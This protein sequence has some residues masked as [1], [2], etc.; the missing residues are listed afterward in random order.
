MNAEP[1]LEEINQI[2]KNAGVSKT[3]YSLVM[4]ETEATFAR[5]ADEDREGYF[6][7]FREAWT[8]KQDLLHESFF[9]QWKCWVAT[10]VKADWNSFPLFYPTG[11]ASEALRELISSYGNRARAE[12]FVPRIHL[13][14]G[15]YEGFSAYAQASHIETL[16]HPRSQ[17]TRAI[18]AMRETDQVYLSDPSAIDG[19]L[20]KDYPEFMREM[21]LRMPR[22]EVTVDLT[23]VGCVAREFSVDVAFPN[24]SAVVFSLSKPMGVYYHRVGGCLSR[25]PLPGLFGNKWFKNITS[26]RLGEEMMRQYSVRE[27]P[28]KYTALQ[29]EALKRASDVVGMCLQ[30][31]DVFLLGS[32]PMPTEPTPL[33]KY[34]RRDDGTDGI[35]RACLTPTIAG[36]I[37]PRLNTEVRARNHEG[38]R[39]L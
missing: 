2:L 28:A 17:W 30:A 29:I 38:H 14:S 33:Q 19:N 39:R 32:C 23:Y 10:A 16:F 35:I 11:G 21:S 5:I 24:I 37:D 3:I 27:L 12:G 18:E 13:F 36:L 22:V 25:A 6:S 31:S 15:E 1:S 7:L 9:E 8:Q 20:W 26:L 34:L 4:P